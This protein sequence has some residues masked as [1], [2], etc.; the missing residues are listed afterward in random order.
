MTVIELG[1]P[2][3]SPVRPAL[4]R[5]RRHSHADLWRVT[6]AQ[7]LVWVLVLGGS[8]R[9]GFA[10]AEPVWSLPLG[11][12]SIVTVGKDAV[13]VLTGG[14]D[15]DNGSR[16]TTDG[17]TRR[18]RDRVRVRPRWWPARSRRL[19]C[20]ATARLFPSAEALSIEWCICR[21][22][23]GRFVAKAESF[24]GSGRDS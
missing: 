20:I 11:P 19:R 7:V 13:F 17:R 8:A 3:S 4:G 9:P 15:A 2:G 18:D 1:S 12:A 22:R 21:S 23:A 5:R 24:P 16:V 6:I 10:I 14:V